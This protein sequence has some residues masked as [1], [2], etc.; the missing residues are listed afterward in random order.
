MSFLLSNFIKTEIERNTLQQPT[1]R[2]GKN[3]GGRRAEVKNNY[4]NEDMP[5]ITIITSR[6]YHP[7]IPGLL[8]PR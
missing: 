3:A 8:H 6:I 4:D 2:L 1:K 5:T 7:S